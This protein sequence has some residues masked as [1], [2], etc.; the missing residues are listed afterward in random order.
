MKKFF[1]LTISLFAFA[2]ILTVCGNDKATE[3]AWTNSA[4]SAAAINDIAWASGDQTWN[5]GD[6]GYAK[7]EKTESKEVSSTVGSVSCE[8]LQGQDFTEADVEVEGVT[9]ST[10]TLAE[11]ETN[12]FT[13]V[14]AAKKK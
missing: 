4:N 2:F 5:G 12:E 14:A 9:G 3:V 1:M 6:D 11:G 8:V 13:I 7:E 10:I